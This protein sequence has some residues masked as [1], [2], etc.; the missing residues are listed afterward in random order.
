M[1]LRIHRLQLWWNLSDPAIEEELH[2]RP[3]YGQ[4]AQLAG[5]PRI[6]E[7]TTMDMHD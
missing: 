3:L 6:P 7:E 4:F 2:E 5:S 1:M